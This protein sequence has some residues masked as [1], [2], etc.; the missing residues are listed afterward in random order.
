[1]EKKIRILL[2]DEESDFREIIRALLGRSDMDVDFASN[3]AEGLLRAKENR[4]DLILLDINL[5]QV[6]GTEAFIDFKRDPAT[7]GI[8]IAFLSNMV[9]PWP[10]I[11]ESNEV[12]AKELGAVAFFDKSKDL[13]FLPDRI[14]ELC[15]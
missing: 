7:A 14:K 1:M 9:T 2:I 6:N 8:P 3:P 15:T 11:G 12:F 5:G 10:G 4:P 13:A